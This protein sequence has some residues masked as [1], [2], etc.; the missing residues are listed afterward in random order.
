M[1]DNIH[2]KVFFFLKKKNQVTEAK[3]I[4]IYFASSNN[5]KNYYFIIFLFIIP[6]TWDIS[7]Q[8]KNCSKI[9]TTLILCEDMVPAKKSQVC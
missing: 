2:I 5:E 1:I 3:Y 7:Q 9:Y 4:Y 6:I 8:K